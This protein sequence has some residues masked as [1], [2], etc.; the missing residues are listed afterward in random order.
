MDDAKMFIERRGSPRYEVNFPVKYSF[1]ED[2]KDIQT[3]LEHS[4]KINNATVRDISLGG[5]QIALDKP[6]KVGDVFV[7]E[8]PLPG[9]EETLPACA[10]V[11]WADGNTGG[12]HFLLISDVDL[13]VLKIYLKKLGFG[14]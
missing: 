9:S 1:V 6:V 11:V 4:N 7:F 3:I 14:S 8:I 10:E 12:L 13:M 2:K 5:M